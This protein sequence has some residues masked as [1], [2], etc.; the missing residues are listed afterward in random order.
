MLLSQVIHH[1]SG[2]L[3]LV[4]GGHIAFGE[5]VDV[6]IPTGNF[7]NMMSAIYAKVILDCKVTRLW[8]AQLVIEIKNSPGVH[9]MFL[10]SVHSSDSSTN[11]RLCLRVWVSGSHS[12]VD[13]MLAVHN[14]ACVK[15][16]PSIGHGGGGGGICTPPL[17][18]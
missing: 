4:A 16:V 3:D 9:I 17:G 7:G 10:V 1:A 12:C 14:Y 6:A 5:A 13:V 2:Y 11:A 18:S 15:C 8:T